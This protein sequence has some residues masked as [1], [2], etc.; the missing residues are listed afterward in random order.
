MI[1]VSDRFHAAAKGQIIQAIAAAYISFDKARGDNVRFFTLDSSM[2]DSGDILDTPDTNPMQM[3]DTYDYKDYS[4]R[5]VS[6]NWSR[7]VEFPYTVQAAMADITF[8]NFDDYFSPERGSSIDANNLSGRP[9]KVYAGF[10]G[11]GYVPQL[12]GLTD[13]MPDINPYSK[14][15][16]YHVIDFLSEISNQDLNSV[17]AMRDVRTDEVL[18]A[19]VAQFGILPNQCHFDQGMN[20]IPFV[21]FD[22]GTNAGEV[23]KKLVQAEGGRFWLDE[24]GILQF[25]ARNNTETTLAA[26][27]PEYS[28]IDVAPDDNSNMINHIKITAELREIQE[29]QIVYT[30][31]PSG[32]RVSTDLWVVPARGSYTISCS[33]EDPCYD[34]VAPTIGKVSGVS[35]FT[36]RKTDQTEVASGVTVTGVLTANSFNITFTNANNFAV[37]IDE[38]ELWGEPAKVYDVLNY[39]AYESESVEKYGE[40]ILEIDDN[41][42]FQTYAGAENYAIYMLHDYAFYNPV[43]SVEIKGDFALQIG[44]IVALNGDYYGTYIVDALEYRIEAGLLTTKMRVHRYNAP[45]Y[46]TLNESVL[47]GTDELR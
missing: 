12:V 41:Q 20:V 28:I 10:H 15:A 46:F 29:W 21:F 18:S 40:H 36:A 2:L 31:T 1:T 35:W 17:V 27:I 16:D 37:E 38:M 14:T 24:Q 4:D 34:I 30:K 7:S 23:I 22:I 11:Q 6:M 45:S 43:L 19:I 13:G 39:D 9:T 3:W 26:V 44:D 8:N 5:L 25:R 47:N 33:L 32:D 42:F